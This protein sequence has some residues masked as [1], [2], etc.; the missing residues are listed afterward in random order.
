MPAVGRRARSGGPQA[1]ASRSLRP[2]AL[3]LDDVGAEIG[4]QLAGPW[5]GQD[6]G[7]LQHAQ[8][9][10]RT[11]HETLPTSRGQ[12]PHGVLSGAVARVC[13]GGVMQ[14]KRSVGGRSAWKDKPPRDRGGGLDRMANGDSRL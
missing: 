5:P 12:A 14:C 9:S 2:G 8:T 7:K 10:Q 11:R 13:P 4:Q 6:A 3:D 1:R